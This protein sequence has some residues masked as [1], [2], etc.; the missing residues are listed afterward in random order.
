MSTDTR[1]VGMDVHADTV[2][3]A[4]AEGRDRVRAL[5]IV[6][7][8]PE[9][10]RRVLGKVVGR[11][12]PFQFNFYFR[13]DASIAGIGIATPLPSLYCRAPSMM[14]SRMCANAS[15]VCARSKPAARTVA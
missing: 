6:P 5:G 12:R 8:R 15:G 13:A 2:A 9:A 7:N 1:F 14:A 3:V 10:I 11:R 4:V